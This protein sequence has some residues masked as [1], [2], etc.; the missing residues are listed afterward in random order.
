MSIFQEISSCPWRR[1]RRDLE[2]AQTSNSLLKN[3]LHI[4]TNHEHSKSDA[5]RETLPCSTSHPSA[6]ASWLHRL[7]ISYSALRL[8]AP[9]VPGSGSR[10][11]C[12]LKNHL[13]SET[14]PAARQ[15]SAHISAPAVQLTLAWDRY[16]RRWRLSL[17]DGRKRPRGQSSFMAPLRFAP[18]VRKLAA[19]STIFPYLV[20]RGLDCGQEIGSRP[21][22]T[23]S[24]PLPGKKTGRAGYVPVIRPALC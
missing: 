19:V 1:R 5:N 20:N 21:A 3:M 12:G 15:D 18:C 4:R 16:R 13:N 14:G 10:L 2:M 6:W 22:R 8:T 17:R 24:C 11:Y 7:F 23:R 9:S